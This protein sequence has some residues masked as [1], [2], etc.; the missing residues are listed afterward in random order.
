MPNPIVVDS[1]G[2]GLTLTRN[3][4]FY[5]RKT[6]SGIKIENTPAFI[7]NYMIHDLRP[8]FETY[9]CRNMGIRLISAAA[10]IQIQ[11][12]ARILNLTVGSD[13]HMHL[14]W[15]HYKKKG[16][17]G[18]RKIYS[19]KQWVSR[20][21]KRLNRLLSIHI[22]NKYE[23]VFG[24]RGKGIGKAVAYIGKPVSMIEMDIASAYPNTKR[25]AVFDTV[26]RLFKGPSIDE[27]ANFLSIIMTPNFS[28][29]IGYPTSPLIFNMAI[30][31]VDDEIVRLTEA[32]S[33]IK[34]ARYVDNIY[35]NAPNYTSARN[36]ASN[37][38]DK[39]R[40]L[41]Y[42]YR[43]NTAITMLSADV[44]TKTIKQ[45]MWQKTEKAIQEGDIGA[46]HGIASYMMQFYPNIKGLLKKD[47]R[48]IQEFLLDTCQNRPV[49][50]AWE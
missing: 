11:M 36:A 33:G 13:R 35:I 14:F 25:E 7:T 17:G 23:H 20:V 10:G 48:E 37:I 40:E 38:G 41:G 29:P 2:T 9:G 21:F 45:S 32:D 3:S 27:N 1:V 16:D 22:Q 26:K 31:S 39:L 5:N 50:P 24:V 19:P 6:P 34:I 46:Y 12:L 4:V 28:L 8:P 43:E 42:T 18:Y 47:E 15:V 44:S 49:I 30:E